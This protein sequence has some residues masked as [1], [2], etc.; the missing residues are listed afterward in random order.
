M[1]FKNRCLRTF[2]VCSANNDMGIMME[3]GNLAKKE[4]LLSLI[5]GYVHEDIMV[6]FSGGVDSALVL[7]MA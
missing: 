2:K 5:K 4:R 1:T 3:G 6:A 7:K